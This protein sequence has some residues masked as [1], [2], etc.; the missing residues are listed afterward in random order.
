MIERWGY[1]LLFKSGELSKL[2]NN[3]KIRGTIGACTEEEWFQEL[4]T[5][6]GMDYDLCV[7]FINEFWKVY[8]GELNIE[9]IDFIK[10]LRRGYKIALLSNSFIGARKK[11]NANYHFQELTDV[12]IYSHEVGLVKPDIAIYQMICDQLGM[13]PEETLFIDDEE[14]NINA[15]HEFGMH[16][17]LFETTDNVIVEMKARLQPGP[18]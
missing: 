4:R 17:I 14:T 8:L 5:V 15:A 2:L 9:F 11:E 1:R 7:E 10:Q 16:T 12:I 6:T 18:I 3:I 13:L